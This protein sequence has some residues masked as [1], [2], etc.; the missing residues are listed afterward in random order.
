MYYPN[1]V[2]SRELAKELKSIGFK[3]TVRFIYDDDIVDPDEAIVSSKTFGDDYNSKSDALTSAPTLYEAQ[4]WFIREHG[5]S[6]EVFYA[7]DKWQGDAISMSTCDSYT[8]E[9]GIFPTYQE[10]MSYALTVAADT[11]KN[12]NKN[13]EKCYEAQP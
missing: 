5:I 8:N 3:D 9:S 1:D 10:A 12:R 6:P 4:M 13:F 11:V 7:F 2:V